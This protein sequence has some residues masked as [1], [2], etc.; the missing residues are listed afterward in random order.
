[1]GYSAAL[2]YLT[3]IVPSGLALPVVRG[4]WWI[5]GAAAGQGNGLSVI[6]NLAEPVQLDHAVRL[7][8]PEAIFFDIGANVGLYTI[9]MARRCRH[10]YAFEP[11][12]RNLRYLA[13]AVEINRLSN[14]TIVPCAVADRVALT[15]FEAGENCATGYV[16]ETGA[17]PVLTV[18]CDEFMDRCG[19]VPSLL[20]IDVEGGEIVVLRGASRSLASRPHILLSTHS[21]A[22]RNECLDLLR[23]RGYTAFQRLDDGSLPGAAEFVIGA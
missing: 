3:N 13:R 12:P 15:Y 11:L 21:D 14:V 9:L 1:M 7:A 16:A 17:Q 19:V 20:K 18:S 23:S 6:A 8:T 2:R 10:V 22:L 4:A 5:A